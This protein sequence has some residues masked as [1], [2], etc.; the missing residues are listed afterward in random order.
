MRLERTIQ[1]SLLSE[2]GVLTYSI[3]LP[4]KLVIISSMKLSET[5]VPSLQSHGRY[6]YAFGAP[7]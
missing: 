4:G 7:I 6:F 5:R 2:D 1:R 3:S